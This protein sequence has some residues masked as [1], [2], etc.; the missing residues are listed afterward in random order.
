MTEISVGL[1]SLVTEFKTRQIKPAHFTRLETEASLKFK[2]S[3][4]K[5]AHWDKNSNL[6]TPSHTVLSHRASPLDERR[7]EE[8][9]GED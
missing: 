5:V 2:I 1:G 7:D 8:S 4:T 6:S 9:S 3:K